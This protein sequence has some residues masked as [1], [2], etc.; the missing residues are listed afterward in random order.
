MVQLIDFRRKFYLWLDKIHGYDQSFRLWVKKYKDFDFRRALAAHASFLFNQAG[1]L[2]PAYT[3]HPLWSEIDPLSLTA[4]LQQDDS[5]LKTI[6]TPFVFEC[7]RHMPWSRFLEPLSSL[8]IVP[9]KSAQPLIQHFTTSDTDTVIKIGDVIAVQPDSNTA[10]KN[11][12]RLWYAYV[13]GKKFLKRGQRL[14]LLWFYKPSDTACQNQRYP[15]PNELFLSDHCNCGDRPIYSTDVVSKHRVEFFGGPASKSEFFVRQKYIRADPAWVS[16]QDSDLQCRCYTN[17]PQDVYEIGETVL[18]AICSPN[19]LITKSLEPVIIEDIFNFRQHHAQARNAQGRSAQAENTQA[20]STQVGSIRVRR[21]LRRQRDYLQDDAE[22][23][24]LVYTDRF[25]TVH[26]SD[27]VRRCHVRFYTP[28]DK[29]NIPAPYCRKGASDCYYIIYR[30]LSDKSI[31]LGL[32]SRPW[33]LMKQGFNPL[34]QHS[35]KP[36]NGLDIFCGGGNFGRGIEEGGAVKYQWA[37]DWFREAIHTYK[38]NMSMTGNTKLYFGSVDDFLTHAIKGKCQGLVAQKGEVEMIS[39]GSPCPG[40][41]TANMHYQNEQSLRNNS[42]VS[43]VLAYID[44]YRPKYA[45]MENVLGMA[46]TGPKHTKNNVFA[47]VLCTLVALGYQVRPHILDS[48]S[49]GAPQ[50]RTRL[51][52]SV[53]A[54]GLPPLVEPPASHSHPEA[55]L[56]RS[57]GKTANGLRFAA[58]SWCPTPLEYTTI[59]EA[60]KDLPENHDARTVCIAHPDH[61]VTKFH[62]F[63][64][65]VRLSNIP[66]FP[67]G[68]NFIKSAEIGWQSLPQMNDWHWNSNFRSSISS[69]AWQRVKANALVP[70]VI[71]TCS[72]EDA[73]TGNILHWDAN[74]TMTVMEAR[75]AQGIP[76]H[77]VIVG[78][79]AMQWK[80]IGNMVSRQVATGW[81]MSVRAA[82]FGGDAMRQVQGSSNS[83]S[84]EL[85]NED[86]GKD[87]FDPKDE[88]NVKDEDD[89]ED[90]LAKAVGAS[91]STI[92]G[93]ARIIGRPVYSPYAKLA[94]PPSLNLPNQ[95]IRNVLRSPLASRAKKEE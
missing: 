74:R 56:G 25:A 93:N 64:N 62:S 82:W 1:V 70:T 53:A 78:S 67:Y 18:I 72:P 30:S 42:K 5:E 13:Q 22:P 24:E 75:R 44:F 89:G 48:W 90:E 60:T 81:G 73:L 34:L 16:L 55:V 4:V 10:W 28:Q 69:K 14:G 7:F 85:G 41:S 29:G 21:L 76:D 52:I 54:A 80:V 71:T 36:L 51:F 35:K 3:L 83:S 47:Q 94:R 92:V 88:D 9:E 17:P 15:F 50:S 26:L 68:M 6:V 8:T 59:G 40:F 91:N 2:D 79:P 61:R 84:L 32:L 19:Y 12:D 57:L 33:P 66:R 38:A 31:S 45:I 87:K 11:D 37:V 63:I 58:R 20:G 23:N 27:V 86:Q 49:F 46:N 43:S 39:A 65:Q 95:L 77:E